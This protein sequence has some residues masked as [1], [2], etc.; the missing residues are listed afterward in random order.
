MTDNPWLQIPIADYEGHMRAA[1]VQQLDVLSDLFAE[2]LLRR[3]PESVAILGI[4]GGNGL[5]RIDPGVTTKVSGFDL[6]PG[7]LDETRQ[8]FGDGCKLQLHC[9][10]LANERVTAEPATLVHAALIFEHAGTDLCLENAVSLVEKGG[11]LSV[12]LQLPGEPTQNIGSSGYTSIL[13]LQDRFALVD[14]AQLREDLRMR[15]FELADEMVKPV[16]SG[17]SLWMGI[18]TRPTATP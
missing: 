13:A 12:V 3:R 6:N 15:G 2:V 14:P 18:F 8:R 5:N 7:Y 10:D 4:A 17:K 9:V 11:A 16:A 1:E